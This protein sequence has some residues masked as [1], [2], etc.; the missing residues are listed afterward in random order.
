MIEVEGL[1]KRFGRRQALKGVSLRVARAECLALV[2]PNGAG[3]STLLRVVAGLAKPD[4]GSVTVDGAD[5][6]AV[7]NDVRRRIGFLSHQPLVY[8]DLTGE[9]NLTFYARMYDVPDVKM[10]VTE[11]LR[12]VGLA[13][14][15][16]DA[17]RTYSRGMRQRLA[18]AR[19]LLHD[20]EVL[21]LDEPY[22]G[23]DN[24]AAGMLDQVIQGA[25]E[26]ARTILLT[27]HNLELGLGV[28]QSAMIL[29]DG[30][31]TLRMNGDNMDPDAFR[32]EYARQLAGPA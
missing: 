21:L 23:L 13:S 4:A 15:R 1:V 32:K 7:P 9:A 20:P 31:I 14:R 17:V 12:R 22:T 6:S 18:I 24:A 16:D 11:L 10:R 8:A 29:V 27:T 19:I 26:R 3:K 5:L 2:G 30:R 25:V 28:S